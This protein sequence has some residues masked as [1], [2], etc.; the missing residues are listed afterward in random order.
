MSAHKASA[1]RSHLDH[2]ATSRQPAIQALPRSV[3]RR[4]AL[5]VLFT[6]A[7][8]SYQTTCTVS[9]RSSIKGTHQCKP[10]RNSSFALRQVGLDKL[11]TDS[12]I[13]YPWIVIYSHIVAPKWK[14]TNSLV[15]TG[16][17]VVT[18]HIVDVKENFMYS[19]NNPL[20]AIFRNLNCYYRNLRD[21]KLK[22]I[23][24]ELIEGLPLA[25]T[26]HV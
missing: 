12:G 13:Y 15:L 9:E 24:W 8:T 3:L 1:T 7:T 16:T 20:R 26:G 10:T 23:S 18:A 25:S 21:N 6:I 14:N 11:F 5:S 4:L 19:Q 2:Q 17:H 22:T